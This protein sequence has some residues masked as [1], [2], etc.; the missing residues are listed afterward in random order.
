MDDA[1]LQRRLEAIER[2]L[3]LLSAAA[4]VASEPPGASP[5]GSRP[6]EVQELILQGALG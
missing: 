4:D 1:A 3:E 2:Q 6:S 5:A